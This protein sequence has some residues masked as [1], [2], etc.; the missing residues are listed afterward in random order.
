[1]AQNEIGATG[2]NRSNDGQVAEEFL[3]LTSLSKAPCRVSAADPAHPDAGGM[4]V[5]IGLGVVVPV[6]ARRSSVLAHCHVLGVRDW[7]Q[8]L[9]VHAGRDVACVRQL[10]PSRDGGDAGFVTDPVRRAHDACNLDDSVP[11]MGSTVPDPT[12]SRCVDV[13]AQPDAL[14]GW[15]GLWESFDHGV[16]G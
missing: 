5:G 3:S 2:L 9:W 11:S 4:N 1:M 7:Q 6:G 10:A 13:G 12:T 8:M 14:L 15:H 16:K